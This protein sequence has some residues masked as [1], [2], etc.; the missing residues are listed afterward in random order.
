MMMMMMMYEDS[1]VLSLHYNSASKCR[2]I[3]QSINQSFYCKKAGQ[4]AHLDKRNTVKRQWTRDNS[5]A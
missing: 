5:Y 1:A 3:N 4:N 2:S